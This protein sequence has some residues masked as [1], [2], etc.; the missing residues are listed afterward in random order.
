MYIE[1]YIQSALIAAAVRWIDVPLNLIKNS[2]VGEDKDELAAVITYIEQ[3]IYI[4]IV[5]KAVQQAMAMGQNQLTITA[6]IIGFGF[7]TA[8]YAGLKIRKKIFK[9]TI[10]VSITT[11]CNDWKLADYLRSKGF[12]LSSEYTHGYKGAR[13]E[14]SSGVI[15]EGKY[16]ELI[17]HIQELGFPAYIK[18]SAVS[19]SFS[20]NNG[21]DNYE[22][23]SKLSSDDAHAK[24]STSVN[25]YDD[26]IDTEPH[27]ERNTERSI[28]SKDTKLAKRLRLK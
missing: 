21:S 14:K 1:P 23:L 18:T 10:E 16:K 24:H 13:R 3:I 20:L 15:P 5:L 4:L 19:E 17:G 12:T 6:L 11:Y 27:E 9:R 22:A 25:G 2:A 26:L 8:Y 7:S 28:L